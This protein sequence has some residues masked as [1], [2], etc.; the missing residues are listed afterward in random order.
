M[1]QV[2]GEGLRSGGVNARLGNG[3]KD[4]IPKKH[5]LLIDW[6]DSCSDHRWIHI[7]DLNNRP[8]DCRTVGFKIKSSREALTVAASLSESEQ[9]GDHVTIPKKCIKQIKRLA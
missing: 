4:R 9:C 6:I 1:P 5:L 2:R 7:P 8:L 3:M